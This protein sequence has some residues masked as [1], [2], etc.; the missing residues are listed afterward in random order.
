M[1]PFSTYITYPYI[2]NIHIFF[3]HPCTPYSVYNFVE[4]TSADP[5][6][7]AF[8]APFPAERTLFF[9]Q[10]SRHF[11]TFIFFIIF[12]FP[13]WSHFYYFSRKEPNFCA[14]TEVLIVG[15]SPTFFRHEHKRSIASE[16]HPSRSRRIHHRFCAIYKPTPL[17][18]ESSRRPSVY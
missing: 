3:F 11:E 6:V 5:I 1:T 18:Y 15:W 12:F 10:P 2:C 9:S 17:R 4:F 8:P 14:M 16:F 13:P 7:N